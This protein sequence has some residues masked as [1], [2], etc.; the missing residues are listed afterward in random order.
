MGAEETFEEDVKDRRAL[1]IR[2]LDL[3]GRVARRLLKAGIAGNAVVV[4]VKYSDFTL[5][6]R[7]TKLPAAIVDTDSIYTTAKSLLDRFPL[8]GRAVRL[9][10]V[11]VDELAEDLP[12]EELSLFPDASQRRRRLEE[13]VAKVADRYGKKGITRAALLENEGEGEG[14][15]E[16]ERD[17][18]DEDSR[19]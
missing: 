12:E 16:R 8:T 6:T 9:V 14:G 5:L 11:S 17:N 18:E 2:L 4:K 15:G 19:G 13:V 3:S 7:R 10:G 1:E